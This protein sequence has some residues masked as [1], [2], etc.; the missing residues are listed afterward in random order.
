MPQIYPV[1]R[2]AKSFSPDYRD[3]G[4]FKVPATPEDDDVPGLIPDSDDEE[5]A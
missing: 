1:V 5:D 3:L 2:N 4:K